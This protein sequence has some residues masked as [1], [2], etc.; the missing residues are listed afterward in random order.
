M[1]KTERREMSLVE[2]G[3]IIAFFWVFRNISIV[4]SL[5][6]RP[7]STVKSFLMRA[8]ERMHVYNL[9]RPGRPEKLTK[10]ERRAIW[11]TIKRDRKLTRQELRDHCA[12]DVSLRTI[13]RYLRKNGMMKWLAKRRPKLT[14]ERAAKRLQWAL[15]RKDW[16]VE[17][18]EGVIWSDECS[19]EKSDDARQV[20]VFRTPTEKWKTE[21]IAPKKKGKGVS[22]MVWGCFWGKN[23]GT[24]CPLIVKSVN[25]HVY[26]KVLE[27][28][29][30]P[31]VQRIQNTIGDPVFQQD[32]APV[33][34]AGIV[35]E[36]LEQ[37]N[38]Q[39]DAH[40]PYS[41]DL[42][43][44]EHVWVVLKQRLHKKYPNIANTPG[45]PGKV[46]ARLAEVLPEIWDTIPAELFESLYKS[47]PDRV[48][49]VIDAKGW[50]TRY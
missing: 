12:P 21:C 40:P 32:N 41:P 50:Y 26:V 36:W 27:Y 30:L 15:E 6:G 49:A 33:H 13:D 38:I 9:P 35:T 5:M 14:A 20:W 18:F 42:N 3:M 46:K 7:W 45:G 37:H 31:V 4:S 34:T 11:R 39:V 24:F 44:I 17:E 43:P 10:R 23:R 19:V 28:L 25:A 47:M 8:T 2:K 16:T 29:V 22:L 48:A 1:A